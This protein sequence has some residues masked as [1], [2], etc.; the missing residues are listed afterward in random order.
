[1]SHLYNKI[2]EVRATQPGAW[3]T[4]GLWPRVAGGVAPSGPTVL[5]GDWPSAADVHVSPEVDGGAA[6]SG[7]FYFLLN[8]LLGLL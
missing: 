1:M 4:R 2:G 7:R 8:V 3:E 6:G 5:Q